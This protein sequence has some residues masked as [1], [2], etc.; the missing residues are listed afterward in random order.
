MIFNIVYN[1]AITKIGIITFYCDFSIEYFDLYS[2]L[3]NKNRIMKN[4]GLLVIALLASIQ[5]SFGS[6]EPPTELHFVNI[7]NIDVD[8]QWTP[9]IDLTNVV[10]YNVDL[11][12]NG[13]FVNSMFVSGGSTNQATISDP[14]GQ[15]LNFGSVTVSVTTDCGI[16]P[17]PPG[18]EPSTSAYIVED[19]YQFD[20]KCTPW[21]Q[22][23]KGAMKQGPYDEYYESECLCAAW[24]LYK[25][26]TPV[27]PDLAG[28]LTKGNPDAQDKNV[29]GRFKQFLASEP[30]EMIYEK[31]KS[32][33]NQKGAKF[34]N[35]SA[36][37]R[38]TADINPVIDES[39]FILKNIQIALL[40]SPIQIIDVA[41]RI[42]ASSNG[43]ANVDLS[44]INN[45]IYLYKFKYNN[46][47]H[48]GKIVK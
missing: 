48:T 17:P 20:K 19:V 9:P 30:C 38:S 4:L 27:D 18:W 2:P 13:N 1:I 23:E 37:P 41:G 45:G 25:N 44:Q 28:S 24:A 31:L 32:T 35:Q 7:S 40:E 26:Q 39:N 34:S 47:W 22:Y 42:V 33:R 46:T 6:C 3:D 14:S 10:G 21:G 36:G 11:S 43:Q 5:I 12:V 29:I 15:I 16:W 8:I